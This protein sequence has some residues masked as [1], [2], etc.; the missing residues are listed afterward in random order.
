MCMRVVREEEEEDV[1]SPRSE[2]DYCRPSVRPS[3]TARVRAMEASK[4]I[5]H[6]RLLKSAA[7]SKRRKLK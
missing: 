2:F 6:V 7:K 1:D 5:C 4:P 3:S